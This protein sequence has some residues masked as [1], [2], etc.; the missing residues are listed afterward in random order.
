LYFEKGLNDLAVAIRI[1]EEQP[2][3]VALLKKGIRERVQSEY[4]WPKIIDQ[5]AGLLAGM[6]PHSGPK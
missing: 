6:I 5:Y 1:T 2:E 3:R 4:N